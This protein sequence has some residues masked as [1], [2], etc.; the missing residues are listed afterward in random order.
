MRTPEDNIEHST[1]DELIEK[2][3][4]GILSETEEKK[5]VC[6]LEESEENKSIL[7]DTVFFDSLLS[8]VV[9]QDAP[10]IAAIR[11]VGERLGLESESRRRQKSAVLEGVGKYIA[12]SEQTPVRIANFAEFEKR[13]KIAEF[14][15]FF[16]KTAAAVVLMLFAYLFYTITPLPSQSKSRSA[17]SPTE[18]PDMADSK[19][20]D[21]GKTTYNGTLVAKNIINSEDFNYISQLQNFGFKK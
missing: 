17:V 8:A 1:Y 9:K 16:L 2:Y 21:I 11:Q 7:C 18:L 10:D 4:E 15:N 19:I 6:W 5:L 3:M 20:L 12:E 13:V 14:A